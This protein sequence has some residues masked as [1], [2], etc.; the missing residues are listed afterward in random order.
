MNS[1]LKLKDKIKTKDNS[2]KFNPLLFKLFKDFQKGL[3]NVINFFKKKENEQSK[4]KSSIQ[5]KYIKDIDSISIILN[6]DKELL[7]RIYQQFIN[8]QNSFLYKVIINL[9]NNDDLFLFKKE[10]ENEIYIENAKISNIVNF[11][12]TNLNSLYNNIDEIIIA[13][14]RRNCFDNEGKI[15]YSNYQT[16][17]YDYIL[18]EN[19]IGKIILPRKKMFK[20]YYH[21]LNKYNDDNYKITSMIENFILKYGNNSLSKDE[22]KILVEY[23][24]QDDIDFYAFIQSLRLIILY[25][26]NKNY[27]TDFAIHGVIE[28]IPDFFQI[29]DNCKKFFLKYH[30]FK[31]NQLISIFEYFEIKCFPQI[32]KNINEKYKKRIDKIDIDKINNYFNNEKFKLINKTLLLTSVKKFI[33]RYLTEKNEENEIKENEN[34]LYLLKI[35][36][37][38]WDKDIIN[39]SKFNEEFNQMMNNFEI[40]TN[41]AISFYRILKGDIKLLEDRYE[42][43]N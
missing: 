43:I 42:E 32:I 23:T 30:N 36:K 4:Y 9:Y 34:L 18:I 31:L 11:N 13:F 37:E 5:L 8:W 2:N 33:S 24:N 16:I 1:I 41:E 22:Q 19:E 17:Y 38:I 12:L 39:N 6:D 15:N 10:L 35:K 40:K 27:K 29:N 20:N 25:L 7:S 21:N 14:S 28:N 3:I 26:I